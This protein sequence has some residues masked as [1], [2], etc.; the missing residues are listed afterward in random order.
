MHYLGW[1][2]AYW[3]SLREMQLA[4]LHQLPVGEF[5]VLTSQV[6]NR[7]TTRLVGAAP[8]LFARDSIMVPVHLGTGAVIDEP[9]GFRAGGHL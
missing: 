7:M 9:R 1:T 5:D 4:W 3:Q 8:M 2:T 6:S